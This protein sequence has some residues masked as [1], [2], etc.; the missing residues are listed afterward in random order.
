MSNLNRTR[1][2]KS[3]VFENRVMIQHYRTESAVVYQQ[4][5]TGRFYTWKI[6]L[7]LPPQ[8]AIGDLLKVS[9]DLTSAIDCAAKA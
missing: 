2:P 3:F 1:L 6:D 7:T 8:E 5:G 4:Y 9:D